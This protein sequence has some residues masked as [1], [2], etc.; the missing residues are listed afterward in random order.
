MFLVVVSKLYV[1]LNASKLTGLILRD[2]VR[3]IQYRI[4]RLH[5][6]QVQLHGIPRVDVLVREEEL[7]PQQQSLVLID[8]L[9]TQ[10][11]RGV[12]PVYCDSKWYDQLASRLAKM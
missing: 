4:T 7:A 12:Y 3:A 6:Q 11:L 10:S 1:T 9:L 5:I 2:R 8:T